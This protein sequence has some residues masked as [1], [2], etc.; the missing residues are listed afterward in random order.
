MRVKDKSPLVVTH[1]NTKKDKGIQEEIENEI[2][3]HTI[4]AASV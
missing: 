3:I 4:M 2:K 1:R